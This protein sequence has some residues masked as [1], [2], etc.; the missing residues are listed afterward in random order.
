MARDM[1]P[2]NPCALLEGIVSGNATDVYTVARP[3][4]MLV[5]HVI[6]YTLVWSSPIE[7]SFSV[8]KRSTFR[9]KYIRKYSPPHLKIDAWGEGLLFLLWTSSPSL[10]SFSCATPV[11]LSCLW[12]LCVRP[13]RF[14]RTLSGLAALLPPIG[15]DFARSIHANWQS[16]IEDNQTAAYK[17][18]HVQRYSSSAPA[19]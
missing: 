8:L 3:V 18:V 13:C 7:P 16:E 4:S 5:I 10:R 1:L 9:L 6:K 19:R 12:P 15:S 17:E 11:D 14:G 2:Q